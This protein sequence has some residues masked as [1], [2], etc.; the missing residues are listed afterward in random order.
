[1]SSRRPSALSALAASLVTH[2][3]IA[4]LLVWTTSRR[5]ADE[6]PDVVVDLDLDVA[7]PA[8]EGFDPRAPSATTLVDEPAAQPDTAAGA[9][10]QARES[11]T[12][13][14]EPEPAESEEDLER[15]REKEREAEREKAREKEREKARESE[16]DGARDAGPPDD[17]VAAAEAGDAGPAVAAGDLDGGAGA[18]PSS[19]FA[20]T[21]AEIARG[22]SSIGTAADTAADTVAGAG[23]TRKGGGAAADSN[24]IALP[25]G[26]SAD[27]RTYAPQGDKLAVLL[28]YDRLRG[29]PWAAL[30]DAIIAPM[31]DYRSIVGNRKVAL[32]DLFQSVLISSRNPTNVVATNMVAHTHLSPAE[33]RRFLDHPLQHVTWQAARGGALGKREDSELKLERDR[34][35]FLMP[36]PGLV[37]LTAPKHLGALVEQAPPGSARPDLDGARA[38]EADLPLWL[39]RARSAE[40]EA[41]VDS[42]VIAVVTVGGLRRSEIAVPNV[43]TLPTPVRFS[44]ALEMAKVGFYVRGTLAFA[45]PQ[46]AAEFESR[47][48]QGRAQVLG[49]RLTQLMLGNFHALHALQ[50]LTLRRRGQLVTYATSISNA[51]ARAG[52]QLAAEWARHFFEAQ[53]ES[54]APPGTGPAAPGAAPGAQGGPATSPV[55]SR[56]GSPMGTGSPAT[57][58]GG[59]SNP[60]TPGNP[61]ASAAPGSTGTTGIGTGGTG[62]GTGGP[63]TG[64]SAGTG[65]GST[66]RPGAAGS[67][68]GTGAGSP[69]TTMR[70]R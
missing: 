8:P 27:L 43:G 5:E 36:S 22:G 39:A 32:A 31:P 70:H 3:A 44:M 9:E 16:E 56:S 18:A 58:T 64:R 2:A 40:N 57:R 7:P 54:T 49:N 67:G 4:A 62:T 33:V 34:R 30:A 48:N 65:P 45:T 61:G 38:V 53:A 12:A 29:T 21:A 50:G 42:A 26:A 68:T 63:D 10:D 41:G 20:D 28:R 51:D 19:P 14:L 60:G 59:P 35:V 37:V 23:Q 46:L 24:A 1:M 17:E 55:P 52:M 66:G 6:E 47:L 25:P 11:A 69:G 15:A 13:T